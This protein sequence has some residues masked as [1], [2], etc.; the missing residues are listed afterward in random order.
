MIPLLIAA[1][2]TP[3]TDSAIGRRGVIETETFE[4]VGIVWSSASSVPLRV[5]ASDDGEHWSDWIEV[6]VDDDLTI[7]SEGR[8][9]SAITHF[10]A[11]KRFIEYEF[12]ESVDGIRIMFFPVG[13]L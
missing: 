10:G 8:Y 7:P 12:N 5:R 4:A 3:W 6:A 11:A 1:L 9:L 13:R 2:L